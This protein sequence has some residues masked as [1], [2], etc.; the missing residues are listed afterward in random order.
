M[1]EIEEVTL[2][3][4]YTLPKVVVAVVALV[5]VQEL[6]AALVA[7][8]LYIKVAAQPH[9]Q[10]LVSLRATVMQ[11]DQVVQHGLVLVAVVQ[12]AQA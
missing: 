7:E 3:L 9:K 8:R 10:V 4:V 6:V 1:L 2:L 11:V 5:Q 12:V